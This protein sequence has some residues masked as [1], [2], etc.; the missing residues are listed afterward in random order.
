MVID[1]TYAKKSARKTKMRKRVI[2]TL[3][4]LQRGRHRIVYAAE[5][6]EQVS[7]LCL[8]P[9]RLTKFSRCLVCAARQVVPQLIL[10]E[11]KTEFDQK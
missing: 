10:Q 9:D 8:S 3:A 1:R 4:V 6:S 2:D 5:P 11:V 7:A